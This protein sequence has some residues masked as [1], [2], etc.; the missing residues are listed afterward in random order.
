LKSLKIISHIIK[1][2]KYINND[3][4]NIKKKSKNDRPSPAESATLF[5][6]GTNKKGN[7][8]NMWTITETKS[9][10]KRWRKIKN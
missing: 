10:V 3:D 7:D 8:G 5:E 9:G 1:N 6:V 2:K 4:D